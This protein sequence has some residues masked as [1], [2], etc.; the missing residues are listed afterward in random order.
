MLSM[1]GAV[2]GDSRWQSCWEFLTL[3]LALITWKDKAKD[4]VLFLLGDNIAAL[5]NALSLRGRG[6]MLMIARE[7]AWR[8]AKWPLFFDCHHL[9]KESN[10][11][12][13][14]LSRLAAVPPSTVPAS[15]LTV[16]RVAAPPWNSVWLAW[17]PR[18]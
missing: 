5:Q 7:I 1:F 11:T 4:E 15:L 9:P 2:A 6:Q 17:V 8:Q 18:M 13:D 12:A 14:A 10:T 16:P 3:L